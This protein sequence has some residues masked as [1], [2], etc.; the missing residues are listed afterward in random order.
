MS[1]NVTSGNTVINSMRGRTYVILNKSQMWRLP[2]L[3]NNFGADGI[4]V[5]DYSYSVK[6]HLFREQLDANSIY[7]VLSVSCTNPHL[8]LAL[9]FMQVPTLLLYRP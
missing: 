8:N 4:A 3:T 6:T 9:A 1:L 5:S 2:F 7:L